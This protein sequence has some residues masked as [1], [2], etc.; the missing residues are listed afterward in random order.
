VA[1]SAGTLTQ[2]GSPSGFVTYNV[3]Y[4]YHSSQGFTR[5]GT[6]N[7]SVDVANKKISL[8]DEFD[9]AGS[10]NST[11]DTAVKLSF[12][13]QLLDQNGNAYVGGLTP[14]YGFVLQYLNTGSDTGPFT[15]TYS[16]IF[17]V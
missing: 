16:S 7:I 11:D 8:S 9:F 2:A 15:Y 1:W 3:D 10:D 12:S 13:A 6:L 14:P 5:R 4:T 17:S